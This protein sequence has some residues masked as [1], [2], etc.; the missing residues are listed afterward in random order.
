MTDVGGRYEYV[1]VCDYC[2]DEYYDQCSDCGD[3]HRR[4]NMYDINDGDYFVCERCVDDYCEC[5]ECG[6]RYSSSHLTR[7]ESEGIWVCDDCRYN[8][9]T[10][11]CN[12]D[13]YIRNDDVVYD[14]DGNEYC[15]ECYAQCMAEDAEEKAI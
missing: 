7:I 1:W 2:R 10:E 13:E 3:W 11:C 4:E 15:S 5:D 14:D 9:F 6:G 8:E 12:C